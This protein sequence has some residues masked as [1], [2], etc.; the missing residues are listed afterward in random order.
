MR[1][2]ARPPRSASVDAFF[3]E[4][5]GLRVIPL[6]RLHGRS[7]D[8]RSD[9]VDSGTEVILDL[10]IELSAQSA[11]DDSDAASPVASARALRILVADDNED[12]REMM[13]YF[14]ESEGHI[15]ATASDG[16]SA[17]AAVE[18]FRPDVAIP[19]IGMPG[20]NGYK[21]AEQIPTP[22][23]ISRLRSRSQFG[24]RRPLYRCLVEPYDSMRRVQ[25]RAM[26]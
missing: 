24:F 16:P 20:L 26:S 12:G 23:A 4:L 3:P 25:T 17:L 19:E 10:P 2:R 6:D 1:L 15:V 22:S 14:L 18:E 7:V 11:S 8:V 21:V 13:R 9:G 5:R